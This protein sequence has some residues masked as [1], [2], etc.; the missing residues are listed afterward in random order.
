MIRVLAFALA[1]SLAA[2]DSDGLIDP[3][4]VDVLE[5]SQD[6]ADLVGTWD[7]AT[8]TTAGEFGP[9]VTEPATRFVSV[10]A[11]LEDGT[12]E[13]S[14]ATGVVETSTWEVR[15]VPRRDGRGGTV[16]VLFIGDRSESFGV[17]GD[18]L[19]VDYRA[20]DGPLREYVRR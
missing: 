10:L 18:Q 6:R 20:T 15:P 19:F 7:L 14:D 2:C 17:R 5:L 9:P 11:F 3:L 4:E 13:R 16:A 12:F 1:V 8:E